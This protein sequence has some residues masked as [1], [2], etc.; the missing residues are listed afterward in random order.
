M[1]ER[2][3]FVQKKRVA[4]VFYLLFIGLFLI[5]SCETGEVL[6][7]TPGQESVCPPRDARCCPDEMDECSFDEMRSAGK[8]KMESELD[9]GLKKGRCTNERIC[10][11]VGL[12]EGMIEFACRERC[13]SPKI[14]CLDANNIATCADINTD[15]NN[16]GGCFYDG[17]GER[18]GDQ[19]SC[20]DSSCKGV[21]NSECLNGGMCTGTNICTCTNGWNGARCEIPICESPCNNGTCSGPNTCTCVTGWSGE[22]CA[23]P[24]C[25]PS[26][27]NGGTCSAPNT[28]TCATGWSGE[29]CATPVCDPPCQEGKICSGP[30]ICC[31]LNWTGENCKTPDRVRIPASG[32]TTNF[33]MGRPDSDIWG[34]SDEQP[35]HE[36]TLNAYMMDRYLVTAASY[37]LCVEAGSCTVTNTGRNCTYGVVGKEHHPINCVDWLQAKSYC[38]WAEGR[39]PTEAE[40]ERAAKGTTHR[41]FPWGDECPKSW[42]SQYCTGAEW[43]ASTAKANCDESYCNDGFA[44]TS[45]VD[46]FPLG[47]SPDGLYDMAGN[48]REWVS[49]WSRREYKSAAVSNPTGPESGKF[50]VQRGGY[51]REYGIWLR[52]AHRHEGEPDYR[53]SDMGF[54]CVS[55]VP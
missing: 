30:N 45:P 31:S 36:V 17:T 33:V 19:I 49:D 38:E 25:N 18:C 55:L 20:V 8:C 1:F 16:C 48:L 41:R 35:S 2:I 21:C 46:Q 23:T 53:T 24:V 6:E 15:P 43:S 13:D 12:S 51:W 28:C 5:L 26:C 10:R 42:S 4:T 54:R 3:Y 44:K 50:R 9:Y 39:L 14:A 34:E 29:I 37:K 40:W 32:T 47:K 27:Q 7:F 22:T 52:V 11:P